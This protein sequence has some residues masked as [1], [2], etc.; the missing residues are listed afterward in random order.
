MQIVPEALD[1]TLI[2]GRRAAM[3]RFPYDALEV[4]QLFFDEAQSLF[5]PLISLL[6]RQRRSASQRRYGSSA[7]RERPTRHDA[8]RAIRKLHE[9]S[10]GRDPDLASPDRL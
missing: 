5:D 6:R 1:V 9:V 2:E 4:V 7:R 10:G 3:L 8:E